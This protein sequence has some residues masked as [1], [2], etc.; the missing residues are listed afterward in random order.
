[1]SSTV[2]TLLRL[3]GFGLILFGLVGNLPQGW[4]IAS[5]G[6]GVLALFAGGGGG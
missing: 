3:A 6:A 4:S 1:M 5:V 2:R